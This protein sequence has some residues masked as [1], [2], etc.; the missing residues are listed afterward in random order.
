M[1]EADNVDQVAGFEARETD[2]DPAGGLRADQD[3]PPAL[4]RALVHQQA[5]RT[6]LLD[7]R[8]GD[9]ADLGPELGE[10]SGA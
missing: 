9:P 6:V 1:L 3:D 5:G 2:L 7:D 10:D 4:G 8:P